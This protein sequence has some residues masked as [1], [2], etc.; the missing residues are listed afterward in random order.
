MTGRLDW[1]AAAG[2]AVATHVRCAES[3]GRGQWHSR[4]K[5]SASE[6]YWPGAF[7]HHADRVPTNGYEATRQA[8]MAA[9]AKSWRRE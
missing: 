1:V 9:F 2:V 7:D 6:L 5:F 3:P 8:A 4:G